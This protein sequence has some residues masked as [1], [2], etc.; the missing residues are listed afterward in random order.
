MT[1][2]VQQTALPTAFPL[3]IPTLANRPLAKL[4]LR[5]EMGNI[6]QQW[7]IRQ[8][9]NTI[10]SAIGCSVRCGLPGVAPYH[11]LLVIGAR[12]TFIRALAPKLTKDGVAVNELLLGN[13]NG[14]FE[15]AGQK[16]ELLRNWNDSGNAPTN[17]DHD[18]SRMRFTLAR[19]LALQNRTR[20]ESAAETDQPASPASAVADAAWIAKLVQAALQPLEYQLQNALTPIAELQAES[21]RQKRWRKRRVDQLKKKKATELDGAAEVKPIDP[22]T[23]LRE[24]IETAVARQ[25]A[26]IELVQER[27]ADVNNQL[28]SIERLVANDQS[29]VE[30]SNAQFAEQLTLH[31]RNA[32]QLETQQTTLA[33][34]SSLLGSQTRELAEQRDALSQQLDLLNSHAETLHSLQNSVDSQSEQFQLKTDA[35]AAAIESLRNQSHELNQQ[36]TEQL[37]LQISQ[38]AERQSNAIA[39]QGSRLDR[40]DASV[41]HLPGQIAEQFSQLAQQQTGEQRQQNNRLDLIETQVQQL[42]ATLLSQVQAVIEQWADRNEAFQNDELAWKQAVASQLDAIQSRLAAAMTSSPNN[43]R[44][45]EMFDAIQELQSAQTLS[46]STLQQWQSQFQQQLV[47]LQLLLSVGSSTDDSA[48]WVAAVNERLS[49]LDDRLQQAQDSTSG[50]RSEI[51]AQLSTLGDRFSAQEFA[52]AEQLSLAVA[53]IAPALQAAYAAH[54]AHM[55]TANQTAAAYMPPAAEASL[56]PTSVPQDI[57]ST[58]TTP[59]TVGT[60]AN[61]VEPSA[62]SD[63]S[64]AADSDAL[65]VEYIYDAPVDEYYFPSVES[66][67]TTEAPSIQESSAWENASDV[68]RNLLEQDSVEYDDHWCSPDLATEA[69]GPAYAENLNDFQNPSD[70]SISLD[71]QALDAPPA[72]V[73]FAQVNLTQDEFVQDNF[74]QDDLVQDDHVE[75]EPNIAE[76]LHAGAIDSQANSEPIQP[77]AND[78]YS[79]TLRYITD[80][81]APV[82]DIYEQVAVSEQAAVAAI[83]PVP[84]ILVNDWDIS[85]YYSDV[86]SQVVTAGS[87]W[88]SPDANP[89]Q[90]AENS[91]ST[92]NENPIASVA[93]TD[94]FVQPS[95]NV[96]VGTEEDV[97]AAFSDEQNDYSTPSPSIGYDEPMDGA[98]SMRGTESMVGSYDD[99]I[100]PAAEANAWNDSATESTSRNLLANWGTEYVEDDPLE[101]TPEST[102]EYGVEYSG[103]Y[104]EPDRAYE[105][106]VSPQDDLAA[107]DQENS[108]PRWADAEESYDQAAAAETNETSPERNDLPDWWLSADTASYTPERSNNDSRDDAQDAET[109]QDQLTSDYSPPLTH[110]W[111]PEN[112]DALSGEFGHSSSSSTPE[113]DEFYGLAHQSNRDNSQSDIEQSDGPDTTDFSEVRQAMEAAYAEAN[114]EALASDRV[115]TDELSTAELASD[116]AADEMIDQKSPSNEPLAAINTSPAKREQGDEEDDS[117]EDYMRKLLARMRG[118]PEDQVELPK[119]AQPASASGIAQAKPSAGTT[120]PTSDTLAGAQTN[121]PTKSAWSGNSANSTQTVSDLGAEATQPFDPDKYVPRALAPEASRDLSAM[122]ELANNNARTAIYKSNRQRY[123]T[124]VLLKLTI[125]GIGLLVGMV[126]VAINGFAV[127]IGLVAALASFVVAIIWGFDGIQSIKPLL[128]SSLVL[129]PPAGNAAEAKD[130]DA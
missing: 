83:A 85:L 2:E 70:Q 100:D 68:N 58:S 43:L 53:P 95:Y 44:L 129:Q 102:S 61:S 98:E 37:L 101:A 62:T 15:L 66:P 26:S 60:S 113:E 117:V 18:K 81:Q 57:T 75:V 74:V 99:P 10:G 78:V 16:F 50:L 6:T 130:D 32:S 59:S 118:V 24:Q 105:L 80:E 51:L 114:S 115:P 112:R 12:Q 76:D 27:I 103:G 40:V 121:T 14:A 82:S 108:W 120:K 109:V 94:N 49:Q 110:D 106:A 56:P 104:A 9:K 39:D 73:D 92:G 93:A 107:D 67:A 125:A 5:D 38:Q 116:F 30:H 64:F 28:L 123:V 63:L 126:L 87:D 36:L 89:S 69:Q 7:L 42:P 91:L 111:S 11:A 21:R 71:G 46:Q 33:Q 65:P 13:E 47:D 1:S 128:Q 4:Q 96:Q 3:V 20:D 122:R 19:P 41:Q 22:I 52:L 84:Q 34:Q 97:P 88:S 55:S 48:G 17:T 54:A 127:N 72:P 90:Q 77:Q 8:N 23:Q 29:A 35:I 79:E 25:A 119:T 45:S 86:Y 31:N 124:S